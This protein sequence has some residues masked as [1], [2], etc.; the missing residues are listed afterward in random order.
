MNGPHRR[1]VTQSGSH[2]N[3]TILVEQI[4]S[5]SCDLRIGIVVRLQE[6]TFDTLNIVVLSLLKVAFILVQC[7]A[8]QYNYTCLVL[9]KLCSAIGVMTKLAFCIHQKT[10]C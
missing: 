5:F 3:D 1:C 2:L 8:M 6:L 4:A 7:T 9:Q 10:Q